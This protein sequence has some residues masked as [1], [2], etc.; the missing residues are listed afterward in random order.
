M[1]IGLGG[2]IAQKRRQS[3]LWEGEREEDQRQLLRG[4]HRAELGRINGKTRERTFQLKGIAGAEH[5]GRSWKKGPEFDY[6]MCN[7]ENWLALGDVCIC[8]VCT[9]QTGRVTQS[10][11]L[12]RSAAA[13][14]VV[15][16]WLQ[17]VVV[18]MASLLP[19]CL[20]S[21]SLS[22]CYPS[23]H[24]YECVCMALREDLLHGLACYSPLNHRS[25]TQ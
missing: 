8:G 15:A 11:C 23:A 10:V 18:Y 1:I 5:V 20:Q 22:K 7:G 17:G 3:S 4:A 13:I 16:T 24:T 12:E 14:P 9:G 6:S 21:V 25:C 2:Q 19:P